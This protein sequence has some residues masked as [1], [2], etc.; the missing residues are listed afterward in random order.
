MSAVRQLLD[1]RNIYYRDSGKDYLIKCLNPEHEDSNPSL[2]V[3]KL[4]GLYNCFS[5]GYSGT[6]LTDSNIK[7]FQRSIKVQSLL[8]KIAKLTY[9]N[10]ML[11]KS[12]TP[13]EQ[14]FRYIKASTYKKFSAFE[15]T[16]TKEFVDRVVFPITDIEGD[17]QVFCGRHKFTS[18]RDK[19]LFYPAGIIPPC[20]PAIV[21]QPIHSSIVLVEGI[22]DMLNLYDKGLTNAVC[23]F[24]CSSLKDVKAQQQKLM[25]YKLQGIETIYIMFDGDIAG[26]TGSKKVKAALDSIFNVEI[27]ELEDGVDPGGLSE[28]AVIQLRK[29][30]Y[31]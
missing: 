9:K 15:D 7:T 22:F 8:K 1:E 31:D 20:Y 27:V 6:L 26:N 25:Q 29:L 30:I 18:E 3:D 19:Y 16:Q 11:P 5:C 12:A 24:G 17:I 10:P 23:H 14:E 2:R 28:D 4:T 13:F 21:E